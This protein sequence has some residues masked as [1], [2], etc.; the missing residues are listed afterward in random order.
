MSE[1]DDRKPRKKI[2]VTVNRRIVLLIGPKQTGMEVKQAAMAQ[3]VAIQLEFQ[4]SIRN[5]NGKFRVVADSEVLKVEDGQ[6]FR[7]VASDDN[8]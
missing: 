7:A 5:N 4:L 6:V 1:E 3:G 2:E 8:S